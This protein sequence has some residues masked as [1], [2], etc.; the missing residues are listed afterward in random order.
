MQVPNVIRGDVQRIA[1]RKAVKA[2]FDLQLRLIL[3]E[4]EPLCHT[5]NAA[6]PTISTSHV[7]ISFASSSSSWACSER[8]TSQ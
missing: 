7:T 5:G 1:V 2:D 6:K 3:F 4:L 8:S